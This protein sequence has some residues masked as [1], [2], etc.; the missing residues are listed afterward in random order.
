MLPTCARVVSLPMC[1]ALIMSRP[2]W[3][4]APPITWAPGFLLTGIDSP[5]MSDSSAML[6]PDTTRPSTGIFSPGFTCRQVMSH[7]YQCTSSYNN[8]WVWRFECIQDNNI[9]GSVM[10]LKLNSD[11]SYKNLG[12]IAKC[13]VYGYKGH[14]ANSTGRQFSVQKCFKLQVIISGTWGET[15][16]ENVSPLYELHINSLFWDCFTVL[17]QCDQSGLRSLQG[18]QLGQ[19][20]GGLPLRV[21]INRTMG[22]VRMNRMMWLV[23]SPFASLHSCNTMPNFLT[24]YEDKLYD[25]QTWIDFLISKHKV[26]FRKHNYWTYLNKTH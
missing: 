3:L 25:P 14:A 6:S 12:N 7:C 22:F 19:C 11:T 5:V 18:H 20:L 17:V 1:V 21:R 9:M 10:P 13:S 8:G 4:M 26:D 15:D 16:L 2:F 24:V 23:Q